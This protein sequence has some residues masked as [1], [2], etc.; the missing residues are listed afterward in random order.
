MTHHLS[1]RKSLPFLCA[2]VRL[3]ITSHLISLR[4]RV[5]NLLVSG[6]LPIARRYW[7]GS[8]GRLRHSMTRLSCGLNCSRLSALL[9]AYA[10]QWPMLIVPARS[11]S[12]KST[13]CLGAICPALVRKLGCFSIPSDPLKP[14]CSID[15]MG[16]LGEAGRLSG[17]WCVRDRGTGL[18]SP[19]LP[20]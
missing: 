5:G 17:P 4:C 11:W 12:L 8:D 20:A 15:A 9:A 19:T 7:T 13:P 16:C 2:L 18:Q 14:C 3:L 6:G 1:P 10:C